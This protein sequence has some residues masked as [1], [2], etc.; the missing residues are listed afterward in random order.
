MSWVLAFW[1]VFA[2]D[3]CWA[4]Y[5]RKVTAGDPTTAAAWA[6]ALFLINAAA[7]VSFVK[8][9]WL[10]VPCA[11]GAVCGTYAAVRTASRSKSGSSP[12]TP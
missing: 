7:T 9:P 1:T 5:T 3:L 12:V 10:L 8:D 11:A 6:G 2:L 4:F